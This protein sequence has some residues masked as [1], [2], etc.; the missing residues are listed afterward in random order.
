MIPSLRLLAG[1]TFAAAGALTFVPA[2][3]SSVLSAS[4]VTTEFGHYLVAAAILVVFMPGR[5]RSVAG[6]LGA[7]LGIAAVVLLVMPV[8]QATEMSR[9]LPDLVAARLG[10][11]ERQ[12]AEFADTRR[13]APFALLELIR[14]VRSTPVRY[15][16]RTF[17]GPEGDPLAVH[18]YRPAYPHGPIPGVIVVHGE[19]WESVGGTEMVALNGYL[20]ARDLLVVSINDR[21]DPRRP[22][23]GARN[24][25]ISTIAYLKAHASELGLDPTRLAMLGRSVAGHLALLTAYTANDPAIRGAISLYAPSDFERWY[26]TAAERGVLDTRGILHDYLGGPPEGSRNVYDAASP[27]TFVRRETPATLLVHGMHDQVVPPEQSERLDARLEEA[28]VRHL[29]VRLPWATHGCDKN[30][31]GPCGQI[32]TYAIERFLNVVMRDSPAA[33]PSRPRRST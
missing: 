8:F 27:I 22:F 14:P 3:T 9:T 30:F 26:T 2:P 17:K 11:A 6:R 7:L 28:G 29:L 16:A 20:A 32:T 33:P 1:A 18:I 10:T 19:S 12:P 4:V 15:E 24:D 21:L 5:G 13:S 25:V 23:P 31:A